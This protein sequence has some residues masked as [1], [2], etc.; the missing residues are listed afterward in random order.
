MLC[1][2]VFLKRDTEMSDFVKC[3]VCKKNIENKKYWGHCLVTHDLKP[4][5]IPS[6][7]DIKTGKP[8]KEKKPNYIEV[9]SKKDPVKISKVTSEN[10]KNIIFNC[11]ICRKIIRNSNLEDHFKLHGI[12]YRG[13]SN[14]TKDELIQKKQYE[15]IKNKLCFPNKYMSK[16]LHILKDIMSKCS[17]KFRCQKCHE[18]FNSINNFKKHLK[19]HG[20]NIQTLAFSQIFLIFEESDINISKLSVSEIS[21]LEEIF[22]RNKFINRVTNGRHLKNIDPNYRVSDKDIEAIKNKIN[23]D[24]ISLRSKAILTK[25]SYK[26]PDIEEHEN[27]SQYYFEK[28]LW[29]A[30]AVNLGKKR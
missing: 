1:G 3:P 11:K 23:K 8:K 29:Q 18:E 30:G 17:G 16:D 27:I 19:S 22:Y 4:N 13:L 24:G 9:L 25:E 14:E 15:K 2:H 10:K 21:S 28:S 6:P 7:L 5:K 26:K 12:D 20:I